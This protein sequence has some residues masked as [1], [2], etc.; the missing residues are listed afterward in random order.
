MQPVADGDAGRDD[1]EGAAELVAGGRTHRVQRL[2]GDQHRH[3]CGLAGARG[4]LQ[5]DPHQLRVG[6][7]VRGLDV[8]PKVRV[9]LLFG[10]NLGKPNRRLGGFDLAEERPNGFELVMP[11]VLQQALGNGGHTP[12][13]RVVQAAPRGH[14]AA[15]LV[16][17]GEGVGLTFFVFLSEEIEVK[18]RLFRLLPLLPGGG[19][20]RN[21]FGLSAPIDRG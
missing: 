3:H 7:L 17:D 5:R 16:D 13:R 15:D 14:V 2:P 18:L 1:Q 20:G 6:A 10:R 4:E 12:I 8:L 11:P 21:K 9:L 19:N